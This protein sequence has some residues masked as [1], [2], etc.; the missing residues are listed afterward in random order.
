MT[1]EEEIRKATLVFVSPRCQLCGIQGT[2]KD[3]VGYCIE[4]NSQEYGFVA[5]AK[6]A[7]EHPNLESL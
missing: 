2:C 7:D 4:Q 3:I 5:D 6:W 1:R